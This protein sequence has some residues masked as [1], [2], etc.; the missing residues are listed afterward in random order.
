MNAVEARLRRLPA[1][2][3]SAAGESRLA[4]GGVAL[5]L[6]AAALFIYLE[7]RGISFRRDDWNM[8]LTRR[9]H[10]LD[11]FLR[12]HNRHLLPLHVLVYKGLLE[13]A[14]LKTYAPYQAVAVALHALVAALLFAFA[15]RRVGWP[16]ALL[17]TA[18][19]A[20]PGA[21]V[22]DVLWPFQIGLLGSVAAGI[23]M[24]FALERRSRE[25]D[26]TASG[27]L[28]VS[29][30]SSGIGLAVALAA[31]VELAVSRDQLRRFVRVLAVPVGVY[32]LWYLVYGGDVPADLAPATE[33]P[34]IDQPLLANLTDAPRYVFNAAGAT[35][36]AITGL[37]PSFAPALVLGAL[38]LMG[39]RFLGG[40]PM[41]P[42]LWA[43]L[44]LP[45]I[46]WTLL[47]LAR[48]QLNDPAQVRH[49]YPAV[50]FVLLAA[51][52]WSRGIRLSGRGL[53]VLTAAAAVILVGN[54]GRVRDEAGVLK[55]DA[56]DLLPRLTALELSRDSVTPDFRPVTDANGSAPDIVAGRYFEAIDDFGS[57]AP[58]LE[59]LLGLG[60]TR[61]AL[62]DQTLVRALAV[63]PLGEQPTGG[64]AP[65]PLILAAPRGGSAEPERGCVVL[66]PRGRR[67]SV[68]L[69]LSAPTLALIVGK[70][71]T[72][73][74]RARRL[75]G[76]YSA[77]LPPLAGMERAVL[78]FPPDRSPRP[79]ELELTTDR[80]VRTCA[81]G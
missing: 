20:V 25:G 81:F 28:L 33:P 66:R 4:W 46:Y 71:G 80:R 41:S 72:V 37:E 21:A 8:I 53:A 9:G 55:L 22:H 65:A 10:S 16:A 11:D 15:R 47:A 69:R 24:L 40:R 44:A 70:G 2:A 73:E 13:T 5:L 64:P 18:L 19:F 45:L 68:E 31:F 75:A 56:V 29:I 36:A 63:R 34:G 50:A 67:A 17:V 59:E 78:R 35:L 3:R 26:L 76:A 12:P 1:V 27:L 14:G 60:E 58:T 48:G 42:R 52:E 7:G 77:R 61:L 38:A 74:L 23:G 62:A 32:A 49:L 30:A 57:P 43:V 6:A 39:W 54:V 79:W 51:V